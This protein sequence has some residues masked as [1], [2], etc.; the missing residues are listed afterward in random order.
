LA[1]ARKE[2]L[3]LKVKFAGKGEGGFA[4]YCIS[5]LSVITHA[6]L[7]LGLP[8]VI[9]HALF[10]A[11]CADLSA[12]LSALSLCGP[13]AKLLTGMSAISILSSLS[14]ATFDCLF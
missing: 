3:K 6:K 12:G 9:S 5:T 7:L 10:L 2:H 13:S 1:A 8:A 11:C 4:K 14:Y